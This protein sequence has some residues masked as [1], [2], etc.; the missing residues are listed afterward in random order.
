MWDAF[1]IIPGRVVRSGRSS[2]SF[3][4]LILRRDPFAAC[5][6]RCLFDLSTYVR[7]ARICVFT[8]LSTS[9]ICYDRYSSSTDDS[10]R[11]VWLPPI[12][13]RNSKVAAHFSSRLPWP[14]DQNISYRVPAY[15]ADPR[16]YGIL[17]GSSLLAS[18]L[19][20]PVGPCCV[21]RASII[22]SHR[23]PI[24]IYWFTTTYS[25]NIAE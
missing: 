11:L 4:S 20:G 1:Q 16:S 13:P 24:C 3:F 12:L 25:R 23:G 9:V 15:P 7:K 10:R 2:C 8:L 14:R 18:R 17:P 21:P 22:L 19:L 6:G 5:G